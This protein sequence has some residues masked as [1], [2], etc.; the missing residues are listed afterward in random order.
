MD[1]ILSSVDFLQDLFKAD[2]DS[3]DMFEYVEGFTSSTLVFRLEKGISFTVDVVSPRDGYFDTS[4]KVKVRRDFQLYDGDSGYPISNYNGSVI[5]NG[6]FS[7]ESEIDVLPY[8]IGNF[9]EL[10]DEIGRL[11]GYVIR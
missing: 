11:S 9:K 7:L 4:K 5:Q 2:V 3:E 6:K 10:S 1:D 8:C